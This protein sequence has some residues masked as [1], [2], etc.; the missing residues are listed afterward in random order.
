LNFKNI[1]SN[2]AKNFTISIE[3]PGVIY[4]KNNFTIEKNR[5]VFKL[6]SLNC[7][8]EKT[9]SFSFHTPNSGSVKDISINFTNPFKIE[10]LNSSEISQYSND[11]YF[12]APV[13]YESRFP[14]VRLIDIKYFASDFAPKIGDSINLTVLIKNIGYISSSIPQINLT[15]NDHYADLKRTD[16]N[17]LSLK[18]I[19]F[20]EEKSIFITLKKDDWKAYFY[21]SIKFVRGSET[22]TIQIISSPMIILGYIEFS[23]KKSVNK[24]QME[25]GQE[26]EITITVENTGTICMKGIKIN[27]M[28]SFTQKDFSLTDGNLVKEIDCLLP[29]E[30]AK[31]T[32]TIKAKRKS[33]VTLEEAKLD[34]YFLLR[35]EVESDDIK[36]KIIY[37][38]FVQL[39]F[40]GIPCFIALVI[41]GSYFWKSRKYRLEKFELKR[42]ELEIFKLTSTESIL[43]IEHTLRERI[44]IIDGKQKENHIIQYTEGGSS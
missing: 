17:T 39:M 21:P 23:I 8:E 24:V 34:Y 20:N 2:N 22:K 40:I 18:N 5:L 19:T 12:S 31:T 26:V 15:L 14:Y 10:N 7:S 29:G 44:K 35:Q 28:A 25:V 30:E 13:D 33:V 38:Q 6:E 37:P 36:I 11:V 16:N 1:G 3:I 41:L 27:D 9:I 4:N 32:Y 43:K 42:S